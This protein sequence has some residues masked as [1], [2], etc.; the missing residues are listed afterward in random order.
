MEM[1]RFCLS[2]CRY[3]RAQRLEPPTAVCV[4][5]MYTLGIVVGVRSCRCIVSLLNP[6][7][8]SCNRQHCRRHPRLYFLF[9]RTTTTTTTTTTTITTNNHTGAAGLDQVR[10]H[11]VNEGGRTRHQ[12]TDRR[13]CHPVRL[14]LEPA[15]KAV[16]RPS[17]QP[18]CCT[19]RAGRGG[20]GKTGGRL[21]STPRVLTTAVMFQ[22]NRMVHPVR[23]SRLV[24]HLVRYILPA[25]HDLQPLFQAD[26]QAMDRAHR[27]G[28]KRPVS[29][30]RL[31]TE[32]TVEEKVKNNNCC[33]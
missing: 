27:I 31:V 11:A 1:G 4:Q 21:V 25:L 19:H 17:S 28:Q 29:V 5:P 14:R 3:R 23:R 9:F 22:I 10:V 32:N 6:S 2:K 26:L 7:P 12:P 20:Y 16:V 24:S 8:T 15:G 18:S 33:R 13:H 30:Y